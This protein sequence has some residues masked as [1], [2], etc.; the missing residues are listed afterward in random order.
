MPSDRQ[1]R[2]QRHQAA[3]K[4]QR[5][6][7]IR[8]AQST[9]FVKGSGFRKSE[10]VGGKKYYT[11]MSTDPNSSGAGGSV[12]N[13]TVSGSS[14]ATVDNV[15]VFRL[16]TRLPVQGGHVSPI[17]ES[18]TISIV[19]YDPIGAAAEGAVDTNAGVV[20]TKGEDYDLASPGTFATHFLRKDGA[21]ADVSASL[22]TFKTWSW[23]PSGGGDPFTTV[24]DSSGDTIAVTAVGGLE[25]TDTSSGTTDSLTMTVATGTSSALGVVRV[26]GG[27]AIGASYASGAVTI[28]HDDTSSVSAAD[29]S[30]TTFI[31]DL[32]FDTYGHVTARTSAAVPVYMPSGPEG[33]VDT[34]VVNTDDDYNDNDPGANN[35]QSH[36]LRKDGIFASP[37]AS[38]SAFKIISWA[39]SSGNPFVTTADATA[40][41]LSI[42]AGTGIQFVDASSGSTDGPVTISSTHSVGDGG[43]TTNDFTNADHT[44]LNGIASSANNYTHPSVQHIPDNGAANQYVKYASAGTGA[45]ADLPVTTGA[46]TLSD[47]SLPTTSGYAGVFKELSTQAIKMYSLK[48][49]AN[50][51]LDKNNGGGE[52]DTYIEISASGTTV[53]NANWSGVSLALANGG[54]GGSDASEARIAFGLGDSATKNVGTGSTEVAAGNHGHSYDNYSSWTLKDHSGDTY[55]VTSADVMQIKQG[56][57]I[58]VNFTADDVMTIT[59]TAPD[60]NHDVNH[61]DWDGSDTGLNDVTG[62]ASLGLG[63]AAQSASGDFAASSHNHSAG[64]ITSGTLAIG[65]GG[66]GVTTYSLLKTALSL[67]NA[68]DAD[69]GT[70]S[71]DAAIGNHNHSGVYQ[72]AGSY[73]TLSGTTSD[74][75]MTYG[76]G[77]TLH[78][79]S[80]LTY[81][82]GVL[83]V[84]KAGA[85]DGKIYISAD[86]GNA[87]EAYNPYLV[88]VQ[89]GNLEESAVYMD[90]N[91]LII[92]NGVSGAG[93]ISIRT[94]SSADSYTIASERMEFLS[95]GNI[96]PGAN[97]TQD[98]GSTGKRWEN[99]WATGVKATTFYGGS[100]LS[101][102]LTSTRTFTVTNGDVHNVTIKGGIITLWEVLQ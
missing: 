88:F 16:E 23:V 84:N 66:T 3:V 5:G 9:E 79:E 33:G 61:Y 31:Q 78:T 20:S 63:T 81:G 50:I 12:T 85:S 26:I 57:G 21:W 38:I 55:T 62:R 58:S 100:A 93:G 60:V 94:G 71:G 14:S 4:P 37:V 73:A 99:I 75:I 39:P 42:T 82:S 67:G 49:G 43:L 24:A 41:T 34:G 18:G 90:S 15:G 96:I 45:W 29:N 40:D 17:Y 44:K 86:E 8:G 11:P 69:L 54:T 95:D 1:T 101:A 59:N 48:A 22:D 68:A 74:G 10:F 83:H 30:G 32:T 36:F 6:K 35:F 65:V 72:A 87:N 70:G 53:S 47:S 102:G 80:N 46:N 76:S 77:T 92:A 64:N 52:A 56:T 97:G 89:D 27:S 25:F 19:E 2:R 28:S 91:Q 7:A 13:I 98:F 51:T